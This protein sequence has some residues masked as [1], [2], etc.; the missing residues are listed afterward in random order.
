MNKFFKSRMM[1]SMVPY[2]ILG[3]GMIIAFRLISEISF[4][5]DIVGRFFGVVAP[6][7]A[8]AIVAYIMNLPCTGI[9]RMFLRIDN[10]FIQKRSRPLSVAVLFILVVAI[11]SFILNI[12]IP[13]ISSSIT[14]FIAEFSTYEET[15]R[16]W[17]ATIDSWN[18]PDFLPDI[19]ED[20]L[21]A[22]AA[23]FL[24]ELDMEN[25]ISVIISGF[26]SAAVALFQTIIAIISSI[27]FL[28]EK[29]RFKEFVLRL[30]KAITSDRTN[31]T[32]IKYASKLNHNFHQYI[33]MQTIDGIILGSI[34]TIVLWLFG[35]P[36]FLILGL[37]LGVL[38]Y[39]PYFGSI[40]GTALAVLVMAFT[41]GVPTAAFA[42]VIMFII[43]QI[44]GNFI[45]PKL[46]GGSFSLSPLLIIISVTIG[47]AYAGVLGMLIAIPIVAILKDLLDEFIA[48]REKKKI[49][50]T[51]PFEVD[52]MD[53]DIW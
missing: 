51:R 26:G 7:F 5:S 12:A 18:L 30:I 14:D 41:Q 28:I 6:F 44:D 9:Q 34:M 49:E 47:G 4:F 38:N 46:M 33:Y 17:I 45:Q 35:S 24:Q 27:Y 8:G 19:D 22:M 31:V 16:G 50:S 10:G 48:Y 23:E 36:Y 25:I 42:A 13:A 29:D 52:F 53:R 43:Q 40:I 3:V 21:I 2:F 15:F 32:I 37:I 39:I 11:F 1:R 20:A